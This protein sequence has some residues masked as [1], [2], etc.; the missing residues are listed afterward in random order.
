M[1]R[2]QVVPTNVFE[3]KNIEEMKMGK[4][5]FRNNTYLSNIDRYEL[6]YR[7]IPFSLD[8]PS[9]YKDI[10]SWVDTNEYSQQYDFDDFYEA[11]NNLKNHIG[12]GVNVEFVNNYLMYEEDYTRAQK[13]P[14]PRQVHYVSNDGENFRTYI[15]NDEYRT[16]KDQ[17]DKDIKEVSVSPSLS[18]ALTPEK[19]EDSD[20]YRNI[21]DMDAN[22]LK[23][24]MNG[25]DET[26][27]TIFLKS[28]KTTIFEQMER[29][30]YPGRYR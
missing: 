15:H 2:R 30:E 23:Q 28:R 6:G 10:Y 17:F 12:P 11:Y 13:E 4:R 26:R 19:E 8:F 21:P 27:K 20:L 18:S 5:F 24:Y 1:Y 7:E 14:G 9:E 16:F 29:K 22:I 25:S 3:N